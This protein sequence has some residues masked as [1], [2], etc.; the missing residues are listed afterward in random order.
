MAC[1]RIGEERQVMRVG[2]MY[3]PTSLHV[4]EKHDGTGRC[5]LCGKPTVENTKPG[6]RYKQFCTHSHKLI[7]QRR[8]KQGI[9]VD[10]GYRAPRR[11]Q[12]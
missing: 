11:A 3:H 2:W 4:D 9:A 6:G 12:R 8:Q 10:G 1:D 5:L 7:A